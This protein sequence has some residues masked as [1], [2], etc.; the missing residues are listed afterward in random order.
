MSIAIKKVLRIDDSSL[1][2]K[3][4]CGFYGNEAWL[5][6]CSVC[7]KKM[8]ADNQAKNSSP[9]LTPGHKRRY[10]FNTRTHIN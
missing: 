5:G 9:N 10:L 2:C 8:R 7:H 6:Y 3:N 1:L 4:G